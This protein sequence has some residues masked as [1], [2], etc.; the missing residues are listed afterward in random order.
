MIPGQTRYPARRTAAK[1]TP[2][3]GHTGDAFVFSNANCRLRLAA[4]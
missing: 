1:A 3:G 2:D 4:P